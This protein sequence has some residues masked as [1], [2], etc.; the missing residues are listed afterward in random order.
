[1]LNKTRRYII[2]ALVTVGFAIL[3]NFTSLLAPSYFWGLVLGVLGLLL[4]IILELYIELVV[5]EEPAV[6][7]V[8]REEKIVQIIRE[9]RQDPSCRHIKALWC[10]RFGGEPE[11]YAEEVAT[12]QKNPRLHVQRLINVNRVEKD[13]YEDHIK[14]RKALLDQGRYE[15]KKTDI[16][17]FE[18]LIC[19]YEKPSGRETKVFFTFVDLAGNRPGMGIFLDSSKN[20]KALFAVRSI[21]SWYNREW[22]THAQNTVV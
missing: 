6:E 15:T 21:E 1:L 14:S 11:Y 4:S 17:E 8:L 20:E 16:E 9:M 12:I 18:C 10:T 7:V 5:K 22:L 19:E 3:G 13:V 2:Y